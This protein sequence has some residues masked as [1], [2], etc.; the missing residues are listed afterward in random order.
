LEPLLLG[1][2]ISLLPIYSFK[3]GTVQYAHIV[4]A[5]FMLMRFSHQQAKLTKLEACLLL[6]ALLSFAVEGIAVMRGESTSSLLEPAYIIFNAAVV[7]AFVRIPMND[8]HFRFA[9]IGSLIS[10]TLIAAVSVWYFGTSFTI[11]RA[12]IERSSGLFNNANQ[13]GYFAVCVASIAGLLYLRGALSRNMTMFLWAVTMILVMTSVSRAS[14]AAMGAIL[15]FGFASFLNKDRLSPM[16]MTG[17]VVLSAAVWFAY[18][19]GELNSLQFIERIKN[20]G[21]NTYDSFAA[22]G[23]TIPFD[24]PISFLFGVGAERARIGT[25][26]YRIEVHSTWW[27]FMGKYGIVGFSLY[28]GAWLIWTR[29]VYKDRGLLGFF[30][31]VLPSVIT[32]VTANYSRFTPLYILIG[33]SLNRSLRFGNLKGWIF[34]Q[35]VDFCRDSTG[36]MAGAP[37]GTASDQIGPPGKG[38]NDAE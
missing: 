24:D 4:L 15:V 37:V 26:F 1:L 25:I 38:T 5:F 35:P 31:V 12:G 36:N 2:G 28:V 23:Y 18:S 27:S 8:R 14:S 7:I 9:L 21:T 33:L 13:Q 16:V 17:V 22:R 10:S 19:Y 11:T 3:S 20:T 6:L 32:G 29:E 30:I 34:K